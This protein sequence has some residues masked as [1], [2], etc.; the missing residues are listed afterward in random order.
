MRFSGMSVGQDYYIDIKLAPLASEA[1]ASTYVDTRVSEESTTTATTT[2]G[3]KR[4]RKAGGGGGGDDATEVYKNDDTEAAT[5]APLATATDYY[6]RYD[7][8]DVTVQVDIDCLLHMVSV[9]KSADTL[10]ITVFS[11]SAN[12]EAERL[13]VKST[14][15]NTT[16]MGVITPQNLTCEV[17]LSRT[18][19]T[20]LCHLTPNRSQVWTLPKFNAV[21]MVIMQAASLSERIKSVTGASQSN[22]VTIGMTGNQDDTRPGASRQILTLRSNGDIGVV[23]SEIRS[24]LVANVKFTNGRSVGTHNQIRF[25]G[26]YGSKPLIQI[27]RIAPI[28]KFVRMWVGARTQRRLN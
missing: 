20:D 14:D 8:Q 23:E 1:T 13:L 26:R 19:A 15:R 18:R 3:T 11:F 16:T 5:Q 9:A 25:S 10:S 22:F 12:G 4:K 6:R 27:G 24:D 17:C 2:A 7:N 28:C 21:S